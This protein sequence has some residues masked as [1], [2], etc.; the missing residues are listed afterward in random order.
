MSENNPLFSLRS[1]RGLAS[2]RECPWED[3]DGASLECLTCRVRSSFAVTGAISSAIA[4]GGP[5]LAPGSQV[6]RL[7][8][9][10]AVART[11]DYDHSGGYDRGACVTSETPLGEDFPVGHC[12]SALKASPV[13]VEE[14]VS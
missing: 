6:S 5:V 9:S 4:D 11:V 10:D 3:H 14:R 7:A 2:F 13:E 8:Q 12:D 1:G